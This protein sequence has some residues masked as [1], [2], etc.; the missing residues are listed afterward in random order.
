MA[1][2]YPKDSLSID[3]WLIIAHSCSFRT[4]FHFYG[5]NKLRF[6]KSPDLSS[7]NVKFPWPTQSTISKLSPCHTPTYLN[8]KKL[9]CN[10]RELVKVENYFLGNPTSAL[11]FHWTMF[12][13]ATG[14]LSVKCTREPKMLQNDE[15]RWKEGKWFH[16]QTNL[17]LYHTGKRHAWQDSI[18]CTEHMNEKVTDITKSYFKMLLGQWTT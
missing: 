7:T 5:C 18:N 2:D 14:L 4:C 6:L 8:F 3:R 11:R 10:K 15:N 17:S 16:S 9:A 13:H 12:F 1:W